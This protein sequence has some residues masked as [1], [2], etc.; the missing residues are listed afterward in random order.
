M[1]EI[2]PYF[3]NIFDCKLTLRFETLHAVLKTSSFSNFCE[4][5]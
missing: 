5:Y 2:W 3:Y 4:L 1:A